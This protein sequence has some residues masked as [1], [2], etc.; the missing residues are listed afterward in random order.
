[1]KRVRRSWVV[2]QPEEKPKE[3]TTISSS[4]GKESLEIQSG[5]KL[6]P[7]SEGKPKWIATLSSSSEEGNLE[8]QS[9]AKLAPVPEKQFERGKHK[10]GLKSASGRSRLNP[11]E[12]Y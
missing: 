6:A 2:P 5:E 9:G 10:K 4:S 12:V 1:M 11:D 8:I 7:V 3:I